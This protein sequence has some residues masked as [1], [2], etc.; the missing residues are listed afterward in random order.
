MLPRTTSTAQPS[1]A[2]RLLAGR[3]RTLTRW[4]S[5]TSSRA[6]LAPTKPV[7]PVTSTFMAGDSGVQ[8]TLPGD[9]RHDQHHRSITARG[10]GA[11][12][13]AVLSLPSSGRPTPDD[14]A[15][16]PRAVMLL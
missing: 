10:P 3:A 4:P 5:A 14:T 6:T 11:V 2:R 9:R 13:S 1:S 7:A 12:S 16:G 15:P 8:H